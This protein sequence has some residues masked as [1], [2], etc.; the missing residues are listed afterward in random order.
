M[1]PLVT[2]SGSI[3]H[4]PPGQARGA[5]AEHRGP[6]RPAA[7]PVTACTR[8]VE[9]MPDGTFR[10]QA[11]TPTPCPDSGLVRRGHQRGRRPGRAV[12]GR[13]SL[14]FTRGATRWSPCGALG[15]LGL[16]G[17]APRS[18]DPAFD[19]WGSG[20]ASI[21]RRCCSA[22]AGGGRADRRGSGGRSLLPGASRAPSWSGWAAQSRCRAAPDG[23]SC[24]RACRD[25]PR[26]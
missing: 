21:R 15:L 8:I 10:T 13:P 4:D 11:A 22:G 2:P 9:E 24:W 6:L 5:G 18:F 16:L 23:R 25:A 26:A 7:T 14:W 12:M 17:L 19:P 20:S 3:R 1:E